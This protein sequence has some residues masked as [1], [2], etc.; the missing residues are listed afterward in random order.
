MMITKQESFAFVALDLIRYFVFF[1]LSAPL[2]IIIIIDNDTLS[3]TLL[4]RSIGM[5]EYMRSHF[6]K[7]IRF[8]NNAVYGAREK[9]NYMPFWNESN[10]PSMSQTQIFFTIS[11]NTFMITFDY[12]I[13]IR[14]NYVFFLSAAYLLAQCTVWP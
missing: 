14:F 2:K 13:I 12:Y 7:H 11:T 6:T 10:R 3:V 1:F 8:N 5:N 4:V 9:T